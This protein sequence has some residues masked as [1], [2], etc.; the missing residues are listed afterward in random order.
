MPNAE[1]RVRLWLAVLGAVSLVLGGC[2]EPAATLVLP[3]LTPAYDG[4]VPDPPIPDG[5]VLCDGPQDCDDGV[6]CTRD[7]CVQGGYCVNAPDSS[8]CTDD[9]FC[10][11]FERCDRVDGCTPSA[12]PACE[13]DNVCTIDTCNE[14]RKRC[15]HDPRD[16]DSDGEADW[17][18]AGGTDCDDFNPSTG[19][20]ALEA[21]DDGKDNDCDDLIDEADCGSLEHDTCAD[22]LDISAGGSFSV[23]LRGAR[24]DYALTCGDPLG[25]EVA[26][27][28]ELQERSDVTVRARGLYDDGQQELATLAVRSDCEA[29]DSELKCR[30]GFPSELRLR[31]LKKGRYFVLAHSPNASS[32][33]LDVRFDKPSEAAGNDACDSALELDEGR[34][35]GSFVD[36][37]DDDALSCGFAGAP[38]LVYAIDLDETSDLELAATSKSG[39]RMALEVRSDCDD[40]GSTLRCIT[41]APAQGRLRS[42]APGR[43]FV[44]VEGPASREVDFALDVA[45]L[46]ATEPPAGEGCAQAI[47]LPLG[48]KVEGTLAGRQDAIDVRCGCPECGLYFRDAIFRL[49]LEERMDVE[50]SIEGA[51]ARM[52][53]ALRSQCTDATSQTSC[54]D[55]I[56]VQERLRNLDPGDHYLIV[57]AASSAPFTIETATFPPTVP[58]EAVGNGVCSQAMTVPSVG[59]VFVGDTTREASDY[60]AT[61]GGGAFSPDAVFRVQLARPARVRAFLSADFDAVLYRIADFGSDSCASVPD[62][63]CDDDSGGGTNSLLDEN[64]EA[65]SFFYVVD[66]Y[67]FGNQGSYVLD[68]AIE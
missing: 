65:G 56:P 17:H 63:A 11:G 8:R 13:D 35:E 45:R 10:N 31:A 21:C 49:S 54:G 3:P 64:L 62:A 15:D 12:P 41:D 30:R 58:I 34:V 52:H 7:L 4:A 9:V 16:F 53:Y 2:E 59:G 5:A 42:L 24:Q 38:D 50:L 14:A 36:V 25:R 46:A 66:G 37:G 55:G 23:S 26:F 18:C 20:K 43:Y 44:V 60:E 51:D 33:V 48:E 68:I 6:D 27:V 61:C 19:S 39:E 28:L 47:E 40:P 1:V 57:E 22:A 32:L 67:G 29:V